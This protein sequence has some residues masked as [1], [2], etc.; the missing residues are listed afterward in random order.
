MTR[1]RSSAVRGRGFTLIEVLV[2]LAVVSVA[3]T[4]FVSLFTSSVTLGRSSRNQAVAASLAQ[5][6]LEAI[7]R[8][9]ASYNWNLDKAAPGELAEITVGDDYNPR[10]NRFALPAALPVEPRHNTREET[11][12]DKFWWQA[13]ARLPGPDAHHVDVTVV[14]RW[15]DKG[16]PRMTALTCSL[17]RAELG[18]AATPQST[19]GGA[20]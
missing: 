15:P 11:F 18:T 5:E 17:P 6:Q 3:A 20:A 2:S 7:L 13:Y 4:I 19:E 1:T 12:Y 16:R 8:D 10:R 9:P 14:V